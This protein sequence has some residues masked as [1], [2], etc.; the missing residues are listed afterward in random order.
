MSSKTSSSWEIIWTSLMWL[1]PG[2]TNNYL[3]IYFNFQIY[4]DNE[5]Q[6][7]Y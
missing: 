6:V 2:G 1:I 5:H 4:S 3:I 7:Q